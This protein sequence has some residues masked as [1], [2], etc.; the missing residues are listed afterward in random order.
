MGYF[1]VP[2]DKT[3]EEQIKCAI[4]NLKLILDAPDPKT[5][6]YLLDFA[7]HNIEDAKKIVALGDDNDPVV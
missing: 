4:G 5:Y 1:C 7:I 3:Y 2:R 6:P